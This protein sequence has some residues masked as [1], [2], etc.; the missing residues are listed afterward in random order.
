MGCTGTLLSEPSAQSSIGHGVLVSTTA[1]R[2]FPGVSV[3]LSKATVGHKLHRILE[4]ITVTLRRVIWLGL[5]S[6]L[7]SRVGGKNKS[8]FILVASSLA[9]YRSAEAAD[10]AQPNYSSQRDR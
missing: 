7:K 8:V 6:S 2:K 3:V 5:I 9:R 1:R 10:Q 4:S